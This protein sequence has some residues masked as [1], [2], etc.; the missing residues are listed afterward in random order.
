M[1]SEQATAYLTFYYR[2][3]IEDIRADEVTAL[4]D[5]VFR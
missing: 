2:G 3:A 4:K 5:R 1:N